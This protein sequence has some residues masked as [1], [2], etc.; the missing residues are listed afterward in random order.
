MIDG[1][2]SPILG[3]SVIRQVPQDTLLGLLS[4]QY[5]LHGGV[6]RMSPGTA[7]AGQIVR[8]LIIPRSSTALQSALEPVP[9][10]LLGHVGLRGAAG[11]AFQG[12]AIDTVAN[13]ELLSAVSAT[14]K[15]ST[16]NLAVSAVG[17]AVM[18]AKLDKIDRQMRYIAADVKAIRDLMERRERAE[19]KAALDTLS[20]VPQIADRDVHRELVLAARSTVSVKKNQFAEMFEHVETAEAAGTYEEYYTIAALANARCFAEVGELHLAVRE[21]EHAV[22]FRNEQA[23]R[24]ARDVLLASNSARF[25]HS[26]FVDILP[27]TTLEQVLDFAHGEAGGIAWIDTL[28]AELGPYHRIEDADTGDKPADGRMESFRRVSGGLSRKITGAGRALITSDSDPVARARDLDTIAPTL[29]RFA[30]SADVLDG[31]VDQYRLMA[32]HDVTPTELERQLA[33]VGEDMTADGFV[34]LQFPSTADSG[35]SDGG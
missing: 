4:R 19:L 35:I 33:A 26:E 7:Q 6:V 30:A 23:A 21:L 12:G 1:D 15:L 9:S 25:L 10:P 14:M 31:Y 24:I 32:E 16:L 18:Y 17:F 8:H 22:T 2:L 5:T 27:L 20:K 13:Q 29:V 28:R 3:G 11:S 34:I